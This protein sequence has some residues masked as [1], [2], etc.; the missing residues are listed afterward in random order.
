MKMLEEAEKAGASVTSILWKGEPGRFE[1]CSRQ[2]VAPEDLFDYACPQKNSPGPVFTA[3]PSVKEGEIRSAVVLENVQDP[4]NV[5]T[6]IRTANAFGIDAVYLVGEC[7]SVRNPKTVRASMGSIFFQRVIEGE[8]P[9]LPIYAAVLAAD[10]QSIRSADLSGCAVAIGS[11]G[12]GL[13]EELIARC[14][15]KVIIPMT[16]RA[17]SLNAAVAASIFMWEMKK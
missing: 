4:G 5:G 8:L 11:E 2:F 12:H 14:A 7:A 15:G 1:G 6:V 16:E 3:I 9:D 17:E 10:S 13:S